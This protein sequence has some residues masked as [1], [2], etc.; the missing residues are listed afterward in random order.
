MLG[1]LLAPSC[2]EVMTGTGVV[3]S[4]PSPLKLKL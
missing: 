2:T 4:V 3:L 1:V